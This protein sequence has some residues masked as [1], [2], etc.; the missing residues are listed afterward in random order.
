MP[1]NDS[2]I[3]TTNSPHAASVL[4]GIGS[5][6]KRAIKVAMN[7]MLAISALVH[8]SQLEQSSHISTLAGKRNEDG[9]IGRIVLGILAIGIEIDSPLKPSDGEIFAGYVLADA[10]PFG[11]RVAF[12]DEVVRTIDGL[13]HRPGATGRDQNAPVRGVHHHVLSSS[14]NIMARRR[15]RS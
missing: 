2:I 1:G 9:N 5:A 7:F 6:L 3:Q 13:R 12:D 8:Q 10:D 4:E 11:E 14:I 15:R